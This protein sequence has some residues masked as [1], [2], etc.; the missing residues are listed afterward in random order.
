MFHPPKCACYKHMPYTIATTAG[1]VSLKYPRYS[2]LGGDGWRN[3]NTN[4][5]PRSNDVR[6]L[7]G[8]RGLLSSR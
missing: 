8:A 4:P 5:T 6:N 2:K 3:L 7:V 1:G